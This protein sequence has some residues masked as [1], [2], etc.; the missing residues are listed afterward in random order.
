MVPPPSSLQKPLLWR[1]STFSSP[2]PTVAHQEFCA[3][4]GV[5]TLTSL[6]SKR[7]R[8]LLWPSLGRQGR[9]TWEGN[10]GRGGQVM[11]QCGGQVKMC[12]AEVE[13][14]SPF[15]RNVFE[16]LAPHF[17]G[18]LACFANGP[19]NFFICELGPLRLATMP[20]FHHV[21]SWR[22]PPWVHHIFFGVPAWQGIS[23]GRKPP[24]LSNWQVSGG[25]RWF[26]ALK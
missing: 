15:A 2:R 24:L 4:H 25:M 5:P 12:V 18:V 26:A 10:Q 8:G 6:A 3:R 21:Q 13:Q 20:C 16:V 1:T 22:G 7:R 17:Q 9:D 23:R 14:K 11:R 19:P